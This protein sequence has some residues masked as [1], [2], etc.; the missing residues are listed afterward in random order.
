MLTTVYAENN[1]SSTSTYSIT[2]K[3]SEKGH[4]YEAYQIFTGDLSTKDGKYVLSNI[5]WGSGIDTSATSTADLLGFNGN[6][7]GLEGLLEILSAATS[8]DS[9]AADFAKLAGKHLTSPAATSQYKDVATGSYYE[10]SGLSVGYYLVK[11]K[12]GTLDGTSE[13]YTNYILG[14]LGAS[15][16]VVPK[17]STP[18]VEKKVL[19]DEQSG[20]QDSADYDIGDDVPFQITATVA[21][22][23]STYTKYNFVIHDTASAGLTFAATSVKVL[24]DGKE[25]ASTSYNIIENPNTTDKCSF[26]IDFGDLKKISGVKDSSVI[27]VN[28]TAKLN[29]NAACGKDGNTNKV[30]LEYSNNPYDENSHG[31][32]P[33]DEVVVFTYKLTVKKV[34]GNNTPLAGAGFTLYKVIDNQEQQVGT[35]IYDLASGKTEFVWKGLDAGTYIVKETHVPEGYNKAEDVKFTITADHNVVWE[36][37]KDASSVL[38]NVTVNDNTNIVITTDYS[39]TTNVVNK[40]GTILPS[41]GG[42]GTRLFYIVGALLVLCAGALLIAKGRAGSDR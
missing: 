24:L 35:E 14:V 9:T 8:S 10:I 25:L 34:D 21:A 13:T 31:N 23:Y 28:Y 12:N 18:T 32:T 2:I 16:D 37:G 38:T 1:S 17:T 27:T 41:A 4:T 26:E 22:N 20:Y 6:T 5:K 11:D 3:N 36:N 15:T 29:E 19:D 42:V 7:N 39:L 40:A 33:D 30:K